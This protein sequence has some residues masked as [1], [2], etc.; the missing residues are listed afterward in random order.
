MERKKKKEK[1]VFLNELVEA[2]IDNAVDRYKFSKYWSF[3]KK[4]EKIPTSVKH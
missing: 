4:T 1:D 2:K 3:Q